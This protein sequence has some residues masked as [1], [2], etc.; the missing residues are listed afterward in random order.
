VTVGNASN[1]E[2]LA[3][4]QATDTIYVVNTGDD[5]V[6]V[7]NGAICNATVTSGCGQTPAHVTVGRQGFGFAAVDPA[8]DL[9]YVTNYLDDTVSV[10]NSATCN[11]TITSG[12]GRTPPTI[13]AGANPAGLAVNLADHTVYAADNTAGAASFLRFQPPRRPTGVMATTDYGKAE[14][15]WQPPYDGRLPIIYHIIPSPACPA[16]RGLTT[17][18]TSGQPFTTITGLTPGQN[19]TFKV[20]ATNAAGTGPA[21]PPSNP[22]TP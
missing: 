20:K 14:L 7:I 10:I 4:N 16:C 11:G 12:C 13:P 19:Y 21:S 5:T 2:G 6:S 22:I 9:V 8:T 18:S 1:P 15:R 3:V 17:P